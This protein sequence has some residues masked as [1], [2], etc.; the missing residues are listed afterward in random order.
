MAGDNQNKTEY[1]VAWDAAH[2]FNRS[3]KSFPGKPKILTSQ[4][5][6]TDLLDIYERRTYKRRSHVTD[7][8]MKMGI[9]AAEFEELS[10]R[11][12][13]TGLDSRRSFTEKAIQMIA[14]VQRDSRGRK[15]ANVGLVMIDLDN[16][17]NV[18]D[19]L[20]HSTGDELLKVVAE[21]LKKE[22][23]VGDLICRWGG[24]EFAVMLPIKNLRELRK[25]LFRSRKDNGKTE[26]G[27]L[28]KIRAN[29]PRLSKVDW[30]LS[31]D[32]VVMGA[33]MEGLKP[34]EI[35]AAMIGRADQKMYLQKRGRKT[36]QSN[37]DQG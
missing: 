18:N 1:G 19:T 16:Y 37:P 28:N 21:L 29:L 35:L 24:D 26:P 4:V 11:D 34:D 32:G 17:K 12:F 13:L 8:L 33:D 31:G 9:K 36:A 2:V 30:S 6:Q 14:N 27:I 7:D 22:F 15:V 10:G 23:R 3:L 20:G 5:S 25:I